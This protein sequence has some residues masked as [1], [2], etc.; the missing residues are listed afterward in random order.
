LIDRLVVDIE[1][2]TGRV[3]NP[4]IPWPALDA[5]G[6]GTAHVGAGGVRTVTAIVD[7]A[8]PGAAPPTPAVMVARL[9]SNG[10]GG[11]I[12]DL[13][14]AAHRLVAGADLRSVPP[15]A[16]PLLKALAP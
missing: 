10:L 15:A 6:A 11:S 5:L 13:V 7:A 4:G 2:R 8:P 16:E 1:T 14:D 12:A 3:V 9:A